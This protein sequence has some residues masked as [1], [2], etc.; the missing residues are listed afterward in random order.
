MDW[1]GTGKGVVLMWAAG[2]EG[3]GNGR[4]DGVNV[5]ECRCGTKKLGEFIVSHF[6]VK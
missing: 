5:G 4:G 6:T 1:Q 2:E 3:A